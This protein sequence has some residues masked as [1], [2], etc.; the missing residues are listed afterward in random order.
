M[1][2]A[3]LTSG[4]RDCDVKVMAE[5]SLG[6][7]LGPDRVSCLDRET[8]RFVLVQTGTGPDAREHVEV[9]IGAQRLLHYFRVTLASP[10]GLRQA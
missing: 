10:S 5:A 6:T 1:A 4:G 8:H 3:A 9:E 2:A 7:L